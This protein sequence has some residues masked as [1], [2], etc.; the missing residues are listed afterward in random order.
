MSEGKDTDRAPARRGSLVADVPRHE[1]DHDAIRAHIEQ[2]LGPIKQAFQEVVADTIRIEVLHV[3]PTDTR[4]VNTLITL[5]MSDRAMRVPSGTSSPRYLELMMTLP[6]SWRFDEASKQDE[7]WF[8]PVRQ[9][10]HLARFPHVNETWLGWGHTVPNGE[11]PR[12]LAPNTKLSG[13]IIVPSLLVPEDFYELK[14]NAH[15]ITFFG[16]VPLYKEEMELKVQQ[17]ADV[18]F[19]KLIDAR[20]KDLV[21]PGR[22][23]VARKKFLGIF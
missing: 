7:R 5:G 22:R 21:D 15:T 3:P 13:A 18:L 10:K 8:W 17:G 6:M 23:N 4:P 9:L 20:V 19:S 11:P 2:K 1:G 16:V 12:R 14:I